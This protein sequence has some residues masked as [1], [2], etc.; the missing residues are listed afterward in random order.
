MKQGQFIEM[1]TLGPVRMDA[2]AAGAE[3]GV[4]TKHGGD[5]MVSNLCV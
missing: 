3:M 4:L 2:I 5:V 1:E